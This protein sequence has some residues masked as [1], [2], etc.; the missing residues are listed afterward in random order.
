MSDPNELFLW[1]S[2]S[3][4]PLRPD[5]D[6]ACLER[7]R[8]AGACF[9]HVNVGMDDEP[10]HFVVRLLRSFAARLNASP[11]LFVV[12]GSLD[13]VMRA[14]RENKLAV[15]F[16]LEGSN[17]IGPDPEAVGLYRDLGV[18]Q[19]HLVYNR[20]NAAGG[21]CLD[22]DAGLSEYGTALVRAVNRYG[23]MMDVSHSSRRTSLDVIALSSTPVVFSHSNARAITDHPRNITDEQIRACAAAGGVIGINGISEFIG[24][25]LG[26]TESMMRHLDYMVQLVGPRHVGIGLD[27]V[28]GPLNDPSSPYSPP[29]M[30]AWAATRKARDVQPEQMPELIAAMRSAGYSDEAV[31]MIAGGNFMRVA[32]AAWRGDEG[33]ASAGA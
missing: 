6:L 30:K 22:G 28:Y 31:R 10:W 9:V 23:I 12:A 32:Q 14:R 11:D 25:P 24:D 16:D 13:D 2:H 19:M 18:R 27:Y 5:A 33:Q 17:M 4:V 15:A 3:C 21:G 20:N 1:D 29:A 26:R 8:A 7:H